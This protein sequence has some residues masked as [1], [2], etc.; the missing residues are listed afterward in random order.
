MYFEDTTLIESFF[1]RIDSAFDGILAALV[2]NR[3]YADEEDIRSQQAPPDTPST[4]TAQLD[5]GDIVINGVVLPRVVADQ[6][7]RL[8]LSLSWYSKGELEAAINGCAVDCNLIDDP[9]GVGFFD[10][11]VLDEREKEE[12]EGEID[13][14]PY[15]MNKLNGCQA[16][17]F[18]E[19]DEMKKSVFYD[20]NFRDKIRAERERKK[21]SLDKVDGK[22]DSIALQ[23]TA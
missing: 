11:L 5:N 3:H 22:N 13:Y 9:D 1:E 19:P 17:V 8:G 7:R 20:P 21:Q 23:H 15:R 6:L 14:D 18:S 2:P 10:D 16:T 12:T 4:E